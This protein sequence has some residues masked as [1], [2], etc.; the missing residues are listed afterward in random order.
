MPCNVGSY[1]KNKVNELSRQNRLKVQSS[2]E[3]L[4][5]SR[6]VLHEG[7]ERDNKNETNTL[8]KILQTKIHREEAPVD[9]AIN[10]EV[11]PLKIL[12]FQLSYLDHRERRPL[13]N[14]GQVRKSVS[15]RKK[16][17]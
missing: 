5:H 4:R 17:Q 1:P 12:D 8:Q 16:K 9:L 15:F 6:A 14:R 2:G 7:T 10:P 11:R 3:N 13:S